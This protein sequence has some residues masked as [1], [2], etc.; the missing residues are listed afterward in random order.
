MNRA[1]AVPALASS[2]F[3]ALAWWVLWMRSM[4]RLVD[5]TGYAFLAFVAA[6]GFACAAAAAAWERNP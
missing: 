4:E 1:I 5:C 3:L 6:F 2:A